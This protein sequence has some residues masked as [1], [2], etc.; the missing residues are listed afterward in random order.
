VDS[1]A[2]FLKDMK[3]HFPGAITWLVKPPDDEER[4]LQYL[5]DYP[6]VDWVICIRELKG[7]NGRQLLASTKK[8]YPLLYTALYGSGGENGPAD[9]DADVISSF[10]I[11][12]PFDMERLQKMILPHHLGKQP[13]RQSLFARHLCSL[14]ENDETQVAYVLM[15]NGGD[16]RQTAEVLGITVRQLQRKLAQMRGDSYWREVMGEVLSRD[17]G[18]GDSDGRLTS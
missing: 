18:E 13:T 8:H 10:T 12:K 2:A 11:Q 9:P 5:D 15:N 17:K 6:E 1:A 14:K 7:I 16:R 3:T 4:I